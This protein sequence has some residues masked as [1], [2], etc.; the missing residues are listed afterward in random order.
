MTKM[1]HSQGPE[2]DFRSHRQRKVFRR[3][4]P[5]GG[6]PV[7]LTDSD[8]FRLP[9]A[10]ALVARLRSWLGNQN[11]NALAQKVAGTAF[12]VRVVSAAIIYLSQILF[13]RWLGTAE[14]GIYVYVWTWLLMLGGLAP[15]GLAYLPQ[16]F[17]PEY[18]ARDDLEGLRGF[19]SGA[20]WICFGLGSIAALLGIF[21]ILALGA[22]LDTRYVLPFLFALACLPIFPVSS[23]QES[24]SV[25]YNWIGTALV[26]GYIVRPLLMLVILAPMHLAGM[27]IDAATVLLAFLA[28]IWITTLTQ[29]LILNRYLRRR[30]P[31]GP[32]TYEP[33]HWMR[34][35]TPILLID[36]FYFLLTYVDILLLK[37]FV[38]PEQIAQYYA[39]SKTLALVAFIYFAVSSACAHRFS[40]YHAQND[41]VRLTAFV[42][43][44]TRMTF[45]PSLLMVAA[46]VAFGKWILMLFGP[47]FEAG[48]P[49]ILVLAV[50]LLARASIGP[51]ERLLN[52]VGQQKVCAAVYAVAVVVNV[53]LCI[54]LVPRMGPL[55]AAVATAAAV[56]VESV[57]LFVA[58][59][60]RTGIA[61]FIGHALARRDISTSRA[62]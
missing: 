15:L 55:G 4:A 51:A 23:A 54:L 35:A 52:M 56:V 1:R 33:A 5:D 3:M 2:A 45:W 61:M 10:G 21:V 60:Q 40:E 36:G 41:K 48:Y 28:A 39:A 32:R 34:I 17:I 13:A 16:R 22:H 31:A 11:H 25:A 8:R 57:L 38:G 7:A 46:L 43:E 42:H 50:G 14:F 53:G 58:V 37:L 20:R 49:M 24:I 59:R 12:I 6:D 27:A 29:T 44:S 62:A 9:G 26:H 47:G 18:T 19:L 30:V